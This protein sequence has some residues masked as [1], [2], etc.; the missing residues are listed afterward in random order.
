[1]ADDPFKNA[2]EVFSAPIEGVIVALGKGIGEA[3]NALDQSSLK[4]QETIDAD[5]SLSG[6]GLQA[7]WYQFPRVELQL[8]LALTVVED[9]T[10]PST[11]PAGGG[12]PLASLALIKRRL[13]A[14]PVSAAYQNHFNYNAQASSQITLSIVPVPAPRAG[15]QVT[16]PPKLTIEAVQA[17]ALASAATFVT[18]TEAGKKIPDPKL[19]F[20][21]NFNAA[22]RLWY[23]L[24]YDASNSSIKAV[25]V[26][27]DDVTGAVNVIS[28]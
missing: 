23:V 26:S 1:M 2:T 17:A 12:G 27:V 16:L 18:T 8:K 15:D 19:R 11:P 6:L 24:Q 13:I 22:A 3:Q 28:T 14:Q 9:R 21:I 4:M 20:D 25:V 5:P 7:T 10:T